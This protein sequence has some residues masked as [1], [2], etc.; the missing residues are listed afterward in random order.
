MTPHRPQLRGPGRRTVAA[1]LAARY[2]AGETIR[3]IAADLDRSYCYVRDL[4][5]LAGVQFRCQGGAHPR[6]TREHR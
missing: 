3:D 6:R 5:D 2:R 1:E 4:L